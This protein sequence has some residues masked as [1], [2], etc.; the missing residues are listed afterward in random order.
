RFS[1]ELPGNIYSRFTNPT[2][3]NFE[4][5]LAALE[6][7]ERCVAT[8]SGMAAIMSTCMALLKSGDHILCSRSVFG[9]TVTL[10]NKYFAKFGISTSFVSLTSKEEW[11]QAIRPETKLILIE[12]PSNP[13]CEVADIQWLAN[14]A[15]NNNALLVVD[16][17]FCTPAL[18]QPFKF[19]A[20]I[21]VHSATKYLDGQ[22]R[23]IGGAVLSRHDIAEEIFGFLRSA[24]P[25]MSP[26]NAWVFLKGL[27]TLKL[28]MDAHSQNALSIAQWLESQPM[29]EKVYYSGLSSHPQH[30]L[31]AKQQRAFGGVLS[32]QVVGDKEAAWRFIDATKMVSI[33]ANLG[34][35]KTTITHPATTT[36]GKLSQEEK[37]TSGISD[38]LI[39]LAIG[40][41]DIDDLKTDLSRGLAAI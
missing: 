19:G 22:G 41:E 18:Q 15:H 24:G 37:L 14:L 28:R 23:C 27:E 20:D 29:I 9:T 7:A 30:A 38:N 13:L 35:V 11:Q 1:G 3:R 5:R 39:R 8:A 32:F 4:Q 10:L 16:N 17:C 21:V 12:T 31:A 25:S 2:V 33:T 26:F 34:D 6:N 36:H 40:L